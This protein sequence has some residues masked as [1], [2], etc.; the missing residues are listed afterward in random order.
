MVVYD[1]RSDAAYLNNP[2]NTERY[3]GGPIPDIQFLHASYGC[4]VSPF[5]IR[6][7]TRSSVKT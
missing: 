7:P 2:T 1:F 4:C 3:R 5:G 6:Y